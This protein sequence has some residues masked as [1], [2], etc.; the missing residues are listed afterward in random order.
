MTFLKNWIGI[1]GLALRRK[2]ILIL[3][4]FPST[5][6]AGGVLEQVRWVIWLVTLWIRYFGFY[7]STIQLKWSAAQAPFGTG[8]SL[9]HIM[10]KVVPF[11]RLSILNIQEKEESPILN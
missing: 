11:L 2:L 6:A 3:P 10:M 9:N 8:C 7:P 4:I 5:G 1:F